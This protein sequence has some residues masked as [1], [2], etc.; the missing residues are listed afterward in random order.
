MKWLFY[1]SSF[2]LYFYIPGFGTKFSY[3]YAGENGQLKNHLRKIFLIWDWEFA[4]PAPDVCFNL[5]IVSKQQS[6]SVQLLHF[7][8]SKFRNKVYTGSKQQHRNFSS[9]QY[10][11]TWLVNLTGKANVWLVKSPIRPDIV[12]WLAVISSPVITKLKNYI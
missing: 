4:N 10:D 12:C 1:Y 9:F 7:F 2:K 6:N 5:W 11:R 3:L 8:R